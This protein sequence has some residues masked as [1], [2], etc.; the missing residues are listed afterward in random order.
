MEA[1]HVI[2]LFLL[3]FGTPAAALMMRAS[4]KIRSIM[5]FALIFFIPLVYST[6]INFFTDKFYRGTSRGF[7]ILAT[8][9][10]SLSICFFLILTYG[11]R[12][13][14]FIP[15]GAS[16]YFLYFTFAAIS[17]VNSESYV[18]SGYEL[19][20]MFNMYLYFV[21][22]YNCIMQYKSFKFI[23]DALLAIII[24]TFLYMLFQKYL[25]GV[26]QPS[27][28]FP[29]RNSA[30]MFSNMLAPIFLSLMLNKNIE[31]ELFWRY[32]IGYGI[33]AT[34]V[35]LS[36]SRGAIL[37]FPIA[38]SLVVA[39]SL[40]NSFNAKKF[41]IIGA[42][43][44]IAFLGIIKAAPMVIDRFQSAPESSAQGRVE[45]AKAAL[46]MANDKFFGVGIN[47]WGIKINPPYTYAE[48][49][50]MERPNEDYKSGL[51]ET[52][53]MLTAAECGWIGFAS[54]LLWLAFY[55]IQNFLNTFRY[56]NTQVFYMP[57]GIFGGL[58]AVYGQSILEWILKQPTNFY[59]LM[60]MFAIVASM[61]SIYKTNKYEILN[62]NQ[63][64]T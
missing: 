2:F 21:A 25:I 52:I 56:K 27:G 13:F 50:G 4:Q 64:E 28:I 48:G 53:Y 63:N 32:S 39:R 3:F 19:L 24:V 26:Y 5:M 55:F 41:K 15:V 1:K 46:N 44:I 17:M 57:V 59:Q 30:A 31:K 18:Y 58:S 42:L 16:F 51:V 23:L 10:I 43:S 37:F 47:N 34:I 61:T 7:E 22:V 33:C 36:L 12:K 20:R 6:G 54:L 14:K 49:T 29:H 62:A 9:L 45:L 60:I 35:V 40:M 8:D 38:T 11:V